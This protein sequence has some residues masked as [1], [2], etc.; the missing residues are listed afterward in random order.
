M[1][2]PGAPIAAKANVKVALYPAGNGAC[3]VHVRS[4]E[5]A[6]KPHDQPLWFADTGGTN[7]SPVG[8]ASTTFVPAGHAPVPA[9]LTVRMMIGWPPREEPMFF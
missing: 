3:V 4:F 6:A 2:V 5:A 9:L 1:L 7:V 8:C